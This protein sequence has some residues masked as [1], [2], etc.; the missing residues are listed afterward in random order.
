MGE[1]KTLFRIRMRFFWPGIRNDIKDWVKNCAHCCSYDIWRNR[2]S[3][4]YFSWPVTTPFYIMHVDLWMPGKLLEEEGRTLQL[5]NCMCDLT[6]FFIFII[7][8]EANSMNLGKLFMEQ[9]VL[10]FGMV[11]VVVV[12]ADSKFLHFFKDMCKQLNIK[13]WPLSRGNHK[14]MSVERYHRFLNKTQTINGE[15]RGS[16]HTFIENSKT[17]QYAWNSAPIDNTDIPRYVAAVGNH[18]KF[19]MDV[20]LNKTPELNDTDHSALY[21]YLRDVSFDST[22]AMSVLQVLIEE[23][24]TAHR[25]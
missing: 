18:F 2:K 19:P 24:R 10:S 6:Q 14:G 11:A 25:D 22:F 23:H 8:K 13:L 4:L 7:V 17:S 9:V 5:M 16:H 3:E 15:D 12:D 20:Q 1:Y 21:N